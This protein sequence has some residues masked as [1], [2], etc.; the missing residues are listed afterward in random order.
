MKFGAP[1]NVCVS[2]PTSTDFLQ[3]DDD[4]QT[5]DKSKYLSLVMSLMYV[6]RFTRPDI[7]MAVTFLATKS[8]DP[9]QKDYNKLKKILAYVVS[10]KTKALLFTSQAALTLEIYADAAHMLHKDSKGHA[11]I[12]GTLGSAPIFAKSFKIKL[13]TRSSTESELVCL[14]EATTYSIWLLSLLRDLLPS[15]RQPIKIY[16][17][18]KS[19]LAIIQ[20]GGNF[21]R[22]KHIINKYAFIKQYVESGE[23][24]LHY[25][26]TTEMIADML[27]KPLEPYLLKKFSK[28]V[29]LVDPP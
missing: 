4:D 26:P 12:M 22:S 2:S 14:D 29:W 16:Q 15:Y 5:M 3:Y 10:T 11:G 19:T 18:N 28:L 8:A 24:T 6:A 1:L 17:D 21:S 25:C 9:R 7:L 13:V 23:I 27:T 20:G